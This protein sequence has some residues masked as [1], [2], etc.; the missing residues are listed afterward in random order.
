[1]K[2]SKISAHFGVT[3]VVLMLTAVSCSKS[4]SPSNSKTT[5]PNVPLGTMTF[6]VNGQ[7][8]NVSRIL[9]D[10]SSNGIEIQGVGIFPATSDTVAIQ[11]EFINRNDISCAT[12]M[13]PYVDSSS[14]G[15]M[16]QLNYTDAISNNSY[17]D[18]GASQSTYFGG[19]IATNDGVT[20]SGTFSGSLTHVLGS[21]T[22]NLTITN[23]QFNLNLY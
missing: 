12:Y 1:M 23:G 3:L 18:M 6:E 19:T 16:A 14:E 17:Q 9:I 10:T 21:A 15:Q 22:G 8:A 2:Q 20:F 13:G 11:M 5:T 7:T 4:S